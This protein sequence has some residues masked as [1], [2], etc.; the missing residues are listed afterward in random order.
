MKHKILKILFLVII[1]QANI[2]LAGHPETNKLVNQAKQETGEIDSRE[3]KKMLDEGKNVIPLDVREINQR[4]EGEIFADDHYAITRG[5]L[6]FEV[7]NKIKNKDA[8]IVTY[9]RGGFRSAL[10][11]QTLRKLGYKN[12]I[13][14][15]DGLKGWAKEGYD[16]DT[17]LGITRLYK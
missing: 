3:L 10:A 12:A 11:A 17:G 13:N 1:G 9:C 7:L 5:S 14:L 4:A 8:L 2:L 16:I 15:K 6:E